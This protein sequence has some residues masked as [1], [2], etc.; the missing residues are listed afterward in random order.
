MPKTR[1]SFDERHFRCTKLDVTGLRQQQYQDHD[2]DQYVEQ[3][4]ASKD[5]EIKKKMCSG[6]RYVPG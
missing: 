4:Q 3:V 6:S 1:T 5:E 2:A